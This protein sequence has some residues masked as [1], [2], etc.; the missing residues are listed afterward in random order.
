MKRGLFSAALLLFLASQAHAFTGEYLTEAWN[1]T[2]KEIISSVAVGDLDGDGR[3]EAVVS[4]S[5]EGMVRA[6]DGDGTV[7]W[8]YGIPTYVF[9]VLAKDF[10][11]DGKAEVV[12]GAGSHAYYL[13]GN[14]SLVWKYYVGQNNVRVLSATGRG[15]IIAGTYSED[16]VKNGIFALYANGTRKWSY[17]VG[18]RMPVA[19][20]TADLDGDTVDEVVVG[21]IERGVDTVKK[22]CT[23]AYNK[24]STILALDRYGKRKWEAK[25]PSGVVYLAVGDI[26]NDTT[27]EIFAGTHPD[28]LTLD[29][30]GTLLWN[31]SGVSRVDAIAVA[32]VNG[33]GKPEVVFG[34]DNAYD[35]D[36]KGGLRWMADTSDRVYSLSASDLNKDGT[37]EVVAGSDALYVFS[38]LGTRLYKSKQLRTVGDLGVG[39]FS[40]DGLD[41]IIV[42]AVKQVI[43]YETGYA[44]KRERALAFDQMARDFLAR[45]ENASALEYAK[46][47]RA[48]YLDIGDLEGTSRMLTLIDVIEGKRPMNETTS[49]TLSKRTPGTPKPAGPKD[50][51]SDV[52]SFLENI[53]PQALKGLFSSN[54]TVTV[55]L[56]VG[57]SLLVLA[58]CV[59]YVVVRF[60]GHLS[61]S[62]KTPTIDRKLAHEKRRGLRRGLVRGVERRIGAKV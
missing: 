16:C 51:A 46:R 61:F 29:A 17:D 22:S 21:F 56:I 5:S 40:G 28:L 44:A 30:N 49:T 4:S 2:T 31:Y 1:Y 33:D 11:S 52:K 13:T 36:R 41:D 38:D 60:I 42:G 54:R 14:G 35:L 34:S 58:L 37:D 3:A 20:K 55:Y 15:E 12:V 9:T 43:L 27:P 26:G 25:T 24:A 23:P 50:M 53:T 18:Y 7:M 48:T 39:D 8:E 45:G 47:A 59:V 6:F 19:V 10:D 62:M 57:F 32:D